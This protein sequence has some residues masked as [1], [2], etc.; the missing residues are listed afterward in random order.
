[1]SAAAE[2][3]AIDAMTT[4]GPWHVERAEGEDGPVFH[5]CH[6][7]TVCD[8]TV[9]CSLPEG[10]EADAYLIGASHDMLAALQGVQRLLSKIILHDDQCAVLR[11]VNAAVAKAVAS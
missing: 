8:A 2:A 6:P 4:P 1:M 10:G 5:V 3:P 11:A 9:V 7:R